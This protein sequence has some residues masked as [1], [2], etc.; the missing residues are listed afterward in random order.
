MYQDGYT[1]AFSVIGKN[2]D[3]LNVQYQGMDEVQYLHEMKYHILH[4]AL[5]IG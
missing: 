4:M 1:S 3:K 5:Y 2:W